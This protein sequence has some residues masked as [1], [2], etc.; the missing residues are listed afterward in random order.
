MAGA[1]VAVEIDRTPG[2]ERIKADTLLTPAD[3]AHVAAELGQRPMRARKI[4]Y[5]AARRATVRE[6]IETYAD[7]KETS[8]TAQ[9]GD[10]IVTNLAPD[11]SPLIDRDGRTNVYVV[12]AEKFPVLY[13]PTAETSAHGAVCRAKGLVSA[14]ALPGGLDILAPW[15]ERQ[16]A[17]DGYLVL[18]GDEVYA[19][20]T[21]AF[22][23]TYEV[24]AC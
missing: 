2:K 13:E 24:T 11:R 14:L 8:N 16:T 18:N 20:S 21:A 3:F 9:P 1:T 7:G 17:T 19:S 5:V 22:E 4:G 23:V 15:G 10:F 6:V 12:A